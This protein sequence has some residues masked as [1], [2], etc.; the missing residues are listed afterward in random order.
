MLLYYKFYVDE[1]IDVPCS[2]LRHLLLEALTKLV[3]R[4]AMLPSVTEVR[5]AKHRGAQGWRQT[6]LTNLTK[7]CRP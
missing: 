5:V 1:V 7:P 4:K 2:I 3:D 6:N